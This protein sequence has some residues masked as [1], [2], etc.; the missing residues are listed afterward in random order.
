MKDIKILLLYP[1]EQS[2]PGTMVKPNGSLAYPYLGGALRDIGVETYVYDACVGNEDDNLD[3]FFKKSKKLPS[4]MFRTGVSDERILEIASKYDAIG[5]TSIFSQQETQVLHCAKIIKKNFPNKLLFSGGV[6]AK[7][8]SS[9]FF[10]SGFDVIFTSES[11]VSIQEVAK[12]MRKGSQDFSTVGK[13]YFK[14][15]NGK[16]IDNSHFG[17][18]IWNLDKLPIPAWDLLPNERYWKIGRPHGGGKSI[19]GKELKYVSLMTSRGCP[20]TCAFC[21]IA[22]EVEG[23]KSGAIG[24]FRIKSDERVKNELNILKNEIGAKQVFIEDDSLFGMK[25]RAIRLL[26]KI[27]G[28]GLELLDVNGVN[29]IHLVKKSNKPGWMVP[30]EELISLLAAVGFKEIVLPFESGSPRILKKWCSNKL[31][32]ER[33]DPGELVNML[34]KYKINVGTNYMLGFPDETREEVNQTLKFAR[35]L[36]KYKIDSVHFSLVMP[37][38]GTP[39]FDYCIEKK[40]LPPDYNPDKFQ[41]TKANLVNTLIPPNELESIRDNAWEEFNSDEFK[42]SRKSWVAVS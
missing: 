3:D 26:K 4:G 34:N 38:P 23:S 28:T 10:D 16:I 39:L 27:T 7:S 40:Q 31:A 29:T 17:E 20:F 6:N 41:W 37:V 9:V 36:S 8:R 25:R 5:I 12:I 13:I 11:E 24:R 19:S 30:D 2:W 35:N 15:K 22:E 18:I 14:N 21:H 32:I 42:K 1:P 33:F